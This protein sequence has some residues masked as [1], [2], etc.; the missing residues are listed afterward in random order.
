MVDVR[1]S[2]WLCVSVTGLMLVM[3]SCGDDEKREGVDPATGR[4]TQGQLPGGTKF[5]VAI[6]SPA[7]GLIVPPVPLQVRGTA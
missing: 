4:L 1:I 6:E 2:R 3:S 5:S 7:D